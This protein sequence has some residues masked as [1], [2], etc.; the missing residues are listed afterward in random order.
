MPAQGSWPSTTGHGPGPSSSF[1]MVDPSL[2]SELPK[3]GKRVACAC[4]N[5]TMGVNARSLN[6]DGT[7]R[8]K[9]HNC[10]Y[11]GCGKVYGKTS[12]LRA[13]LRWH[14][15]E[16]PF[17][18]T[19]P[20]C[21]K[22]FTRSDEL[23]RHSRTHTGE[24]RFKCEVCGKRFMRSDHLN[25]HSKTHQLPPFSSDEENA[26]ETP[27][28]SQSPPA[29]PTSEV[30]AADTTAESSSDYTSSQG[31]TASA[32]LPCPPVASASSQ[33]G[34]MPLHHQDLIETSISAPV[35]TG[36]LDVP[37]P[38]YPQPQVLTHMDLPPVQ[39][40][41]LQSFEQIMYHNAATMVTAGSSAGPQSM[42]H[43]HQQLPQQDEGANSSE[44]LYPLYH[45]PPI[46][47]PVHPQTPAPCPIPQYNVNNSIPGIPTIQPPA[48]LMHPI[49][50]LHHPH[51]TP[52][53]QV[54]YQLQ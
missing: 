19:W 8:K 1:H 12:H 42:M 13:H 36:P 28:S 21:L 14:T 26:D 44:V 43:H 24:K 51:S 23:Q 48:S 50:V 46:P 31:S 52:Y 27:Q 54:S 32:A 11:P 15:G 4:P 35:V 39:Q 37:L 9:R 40:H 29:S 3:R 18:C 17:I 45:V 38:S 25:K 16:R 5:C 7:P 2:M 6:A 41:M 47:I 49:P 10:H 53:P 33:L 22:R 20:Y 30:A 34:S